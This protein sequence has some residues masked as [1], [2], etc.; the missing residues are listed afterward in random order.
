MCVLRLTFRFW[1]KSSAGARCRFQARHL[2]LAMPP[3]EEERCSGEREEPRHGEEHDHHDEQLLRRV[4]ALGSGERRVVAAIKWRKRRG[5]G[6]WWL[7]V[8]GA[9][10]QGLQ[11]QTSRGTRNQVML[12]APAPVEMMVAPGE[13]AVRTGGDE[14]ATGK[15]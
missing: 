9:A 14:A 11:Q 4:V 7:A 13:V 6:R 1:R 10:Q 15:V 3:P 2:H 5:R 12:G 8:V